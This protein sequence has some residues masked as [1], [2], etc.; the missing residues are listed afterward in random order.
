VAIEKTGKGE[1][2]NLVT[3]HDA[4]FSRARIISYTAQKETQVFGI[5]KPWSSWKRKI[6]IDGDRKRLLKMDGV[7]AGIQKFVNDIKFYFGVRPMEMEIV[8]DEADD[9]RLGSLI[10]I[11]PFLGTLSSGTFWLRDKESMFEIIRILFLDAVVGNNDRM[12]IN[13]LLTKNLEVFAIDEGE[14]F[15]WYAPIRCQFKVSYRQHIHHFSVEQSD[16]ITRYK[17]HLTKHSKDV[18]KLASSYFSNPI[19][20]AVLKNRLDNLDEIAERILCP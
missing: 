16:W 7:K 14:S 2:V 11:V 6:I 10:T 15:R 12:T 9:K 20:P 18:V 19:I 8:Y 13:V 3:E 1:L 17:K 4:V 5:P